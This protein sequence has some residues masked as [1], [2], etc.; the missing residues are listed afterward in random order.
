MRLGNDGNIHKLCNLCS[1]CRCIDCKGR[2]HKSS[3]D[4][5]MLDNI[6]SLISFLI[7]MVRAG[8][9]SGANC[10]GP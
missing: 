2:I 4:D 8:E 3:F 1:P 10:P 6:V 5:R 9:R 7:V